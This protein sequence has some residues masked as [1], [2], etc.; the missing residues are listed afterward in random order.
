MFRTSRIWHLAEDDTIAV[1]HGYISV[2][3]D[4]MP[5]DATDATRALCISAGLQPRDF[6]IFASRIGSTLLQ[7]QDA[8]FIVTD[9]QSDGSGVIVHS[10]KVLERPK[11][12]L[13]PRAIDMWKYL[14]LESPGIFE[15]FGLQS[16]RTHIY[17][18][19]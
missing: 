9:V 19:Y 14:D 8:G 2:D 16:L 11:D 15:E 7:D 1:R 13:S 5:Q 3:P 10:D 4:D 12:W 6:A 18:T 17:K